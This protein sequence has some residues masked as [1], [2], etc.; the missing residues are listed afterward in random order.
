M[1]EFIDELVTY[2]K[3]S[4]RI[5]DRVGSGAAAR[6]YPE[7][8]KQGAALPYLIIQEAGGENPEI[9]SGYGGCGMVQSSWHIYACAA[10]Q[11]AASSLAEHVRLAPMQGFRGLMGSTYVS[12][13]SCAQHRDSGEDAP[14]DGSDASRYW[15]RRVYDIW[16]EQ[17]TS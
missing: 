13:V 4:T 3:S 17:P 9:L 16:H 2:L 6:I 7:K 8:A 12:E 5:T 10:S 11:T 1:A 15:S 14:V